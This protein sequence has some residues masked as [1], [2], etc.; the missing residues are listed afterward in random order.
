MNDKTIFYMIFLICQGKNEKQVCFCPGKYKKS[1]KKHR[2]FR[3]TS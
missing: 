1:Q 3:Q 2:F